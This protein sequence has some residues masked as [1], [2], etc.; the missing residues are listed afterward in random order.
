M[1][2]HNRPLPEELQFRFHSVITLNNT[3]YDIKQKKSA[4]LAADLV[5]F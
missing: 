4:A 1:M 2:A 3:I 5:F